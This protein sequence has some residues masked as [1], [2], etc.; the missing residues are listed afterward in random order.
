MSSDYTVQL[1]R[2]A[3]DDLNEIVTFL[4]Q[5]SMDAAE[6]FLSKTELGLRELSN[7]PRKGFVPNEHRLAAG[8][9]RYTTIEGCLILYTMEEE[10]VLIHRVLPHARK[11]KQIL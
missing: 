7:H 4:C 2:A 1:L 6:R 9:F 3:E 10:I 5:D 11:Y 8:N